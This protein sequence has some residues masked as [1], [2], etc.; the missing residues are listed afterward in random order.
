[1][2]RKAGHLDSTA[3]FFPKRSVLFGIDG[4]RSSG[5]RYQKP[6][7]DA[8]VAVLASRV[9]L[10]SLLLGGEGVCVCGARDLGASACRA[11]LK[12]PPWRSMKS[13]VVVMMLLER[14]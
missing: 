14:I 5:M 13:V 10:D 3:S 9:C 8:R 11:L 1:M 6:D 4:C 2:S 12:R 7:A